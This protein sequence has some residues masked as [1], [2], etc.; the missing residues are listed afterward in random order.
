MQYTNYEEDIVLRYGILLEGWT[1][2]KFN[3]PSNLSTSLPPLQKL[4]DALTSGTCHFIKLTPPQLATRKAEHAAK[5]ASG[6]IP[7]RQRKTRKDAGKKR[8]H[9]GADLEESEGNDG[10]EGG[11]A[12]PGSQS[13]KRARKS[14]AVVET[15]SEEQ[16]PN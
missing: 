1:H 6:E 10:G 9:P 13:G 4:L 8:P 11:T 14:A 3:N 12:H 16:D 7:P 5:Q 2:P 15:D